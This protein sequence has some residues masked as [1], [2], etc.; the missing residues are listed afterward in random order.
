M[1]QGARFDVA[2]IGGGPA[3]ST[4]GTLVRKYNPDVRVLIIERERFPREHIGE[5][6]LPPI[7]PI[8][9]EMGVWDK[10]EAANFPIKIGATYRWGSYQ[11]L[12]DFEFIPPSHFRDEP[13]PAQRQGFRRLTA[14]QVDRATYDDILL[15]HS[16]SLGCEVWEESPV[17]G[18]VRDGDRIAR[19]QV[20]RGEGMVEVEAT[21]VVDA[22]GD[23][24]FLRREFDINI[25]VP[26][27]LKNMAMWDY[28][29]NAQWAVE[30][31]VGGT[32]VQIIS[33]NYGW[34][35][36]IP[37]GPT[38]TS[39]GL[40][41]PTEYYKTS[42]R[43]PEE[44]YE[45]AIKD[46]P[47]ISKLIEGATREG[48]V[49]KTRDWSYVSKRLTGENWFLAGQSGGFADPILSAGMTLAHTGARQVA[50]ILVEAFKEDA[51]SRLDIDWLKSF[52]D[53]SQRKRIQQ[54][55]R[56]AEYWYASNGHFTDLYK[57]TSEIARESGLNLDPRMAFRWLS[58]GGLNHEDFLGPGLA[59]MDVLSVKEVTKI[60]SGQ[61]DL[62]WEI[63]KY[64]V[65]K[66]NFEGADKDHV[67][68]FHKGVITR[69]PCYRRG[70]QILPMTG[71]FRLVAQAIRE[72]ATADEI[73]ADLKMRAAAPEQAMGMG[74]SQFIAQAMS[75][76]ETMVL[77]GWVIGKLDPR[78][79]RLNFQPPE[80]LDYNIHANRDDIEKRRVM[81][82]DKS[83]R[84]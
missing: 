38:R 8:L 33:V 64:N 32:R 68:L 73:Q 10:V 83:A 77:D 11:D 55:I 72:R 82:V 56:F 67:P 18:I 63:N 58:F 36:F 60:F 79:P 59:T 14:F 15:R 31:G 75:T 22:S 71:L 80:A 61:K 57:F 78:K 76:L 44:L 4:V 54:Y 16:E 28:W 48:V 74:P 6:Q 12:W 19:L 17:R 41:V 9:E 47:R 29:S 53:Q 23:S 37:L 39:I 69:V 25:E 5:S 30:I 24:G 20:Q 40:V 27:S 21:Y 84:F 43:T 66:M 13:R 46:A 65:F 3:G 62:T 70:P 7:G 42:G 50:Y 26:S 45:R 34:L 35:W 2:I 51:K 1:A 81:T 49:R 52:Y